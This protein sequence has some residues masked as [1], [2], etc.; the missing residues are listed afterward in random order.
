MKSSVVIEYSGK[1]PSVNHM[2]GR[3]AW[4]GLYLKKEGKALKAFVA[5]SVSHR[6]KM[7]KDREMG[8]KLQIS[9]NWYNRPSSKTR[10][11]KRDSNNLIKLI[12]DACCEALEIEDSQIF[13]EQ[14]QKINNPD[15][16]KEGFKIEIYELPKF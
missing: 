14:V 8:Y 6:D 15:A 13:H 10:I 11:K 5:A 16:A 7:E 12:I 9:A 4:G 2:Y 1:L 3:N